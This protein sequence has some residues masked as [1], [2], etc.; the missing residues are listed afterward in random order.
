MWIKN[1]LLSNTVAKRINDPENDSKDRL[2]WDREFFQS[3]STAVG[4][5]KMLTRLLSLRRP[6]FNGLKL[7]FYHKRRIFGI[8][9][10]IELVRG[11]AF[12]GKYTLYLRHMNL[13]STSLCSLLLTGLPLWRLLE[14]DLLK[15]FIEKFV[16]RLTIFIA[17]FNKS[18]VCKIVIPE[19]I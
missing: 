4:Q 11:K 10:G 7:E 13:Y 15:I 16:V 6:F 9:L 8:S 2:R 5:S 18:Y 17:C 1:K 12:S 14:T 3:Y 19:H